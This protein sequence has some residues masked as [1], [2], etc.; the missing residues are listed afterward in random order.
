MPNKKKTEEVKILE[1]KLE[2]IQAFFLADYSG[3]PVNAQ[4]ELREKVKD[5]GGELRVTKNTLL[6]IALNN[7]GYDADAIATELTGQNITLYAKSDPVA[8]LKALVEFAKENEKP[9]LKVGFLGTVQLTSSKIA[10]LAALP[11]K[12][13][14][15][16]K[17]MGSIQAPL[18]GLV[19]VLSAPS[20]NLV[21]ALNTIKELKGSQTK[22]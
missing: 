3:L 15:I 19:N 20:R 10:E 8:P 21:Y 4:Q 12:A 7:K 14:L 1:E 18:S 16:A 2:G 11:T 6:K 22:E 9:E 17:V 5:A 13:E